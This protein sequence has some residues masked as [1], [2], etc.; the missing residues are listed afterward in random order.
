MDVGVGG[1]GVADTFTV[2][3]DTSTACVGVAL[4]STV[5]PCEMGTGIVSVGV[6]WDNPQARDT[7]ANIMDIIRNRERGG[8]ETI[9]YLLR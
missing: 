3:E 2:G 4:T 7:N 8:Q 6:F 5:I 9:R 1:I